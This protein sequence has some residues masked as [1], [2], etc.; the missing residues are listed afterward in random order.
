MLLHPR[1]ITLAFCLKGKSGF[2]WIHNN[3][4]NWL[5]GKY[6]QSFN[7]LIEVEVVEGHWAENGKVPSSIPNVDKPRDAFCQCSGHVGPWMCWHRDV[8]CSL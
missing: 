7:T 1:T 5:F 2:T 8:N 3:A 6:F 4:T